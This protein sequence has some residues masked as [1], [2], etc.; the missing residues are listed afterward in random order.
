MDTIWT[1]VRVAVR[2]L[3]G[4]PLF[5]CTALIT[6][7]IG[8]GANSAIFTIVNGVLLR[9][10]PY[11][12]PGRLVM[13]SAV[14]RGETS[15]IFSGPVFFALQE[16]AHT[17]SAVAIT[18][19]STA[20]L[21]DDGAEP[22]R[23]SGMR[24][25]A[26]YFD[27]VGITPLR[28]RTFRVE[29]NEP[30]TTVVILS[31]SLWRERFNGDEGVIGRKVE[32]NGRQHEIIGIM[33]ATASVSPE[34]RYWMPLSYD[35]FL[36][37]P[38]NVLSLSYQLVARLAPGVTLE[39]ASA[40]VAAVVE[41]T[42]QANGMEHPQYSGAVLP[43]RDVYVGDA[44]T[45]LLVLL[46]AV[47]F[48]LL[49]VCANLANLLL[50]QAAARSTDFAVRRALGAS[51][52][53]LVRQLMT[54][55][56]VLG[57]LGGAAGLLI[58]AWGAEALLRIMPPDLPRMPGMTIDGRVL[59]F[60]MGV[61]LLAAVLFGLAPAAHAWRTAVAPELRAGG[62]GLAGRGSAT[63]RAGLV[64]AETALAFALVIGAGLLIRSFSELRHV[65]TGFDAESRLTYSVNLPVVRSGDDERVTLFWHQLLERTRALPGVIQ[66]GAV[67]HL[68][69]GGSGMT[70]TF[71]VEGMPPAT[72][73]EEPALEVRVATPGYFEAMGI[74]LRVGRLFDDSDRA[75]AMP[76]ALLSESAAAR[77]FPGENPIGRRIIMGWIRNDEEVEGT[78]IGVVGSVRHSELR[79][80]SEAEI[81]FPVA[82]VGR[83]AM[84]M[85]LHTQG[86]PLAVAQA[87]K[88]VVH[89]LDG[90]LAVGEL[91]P[92]SEVVAMSAA[93]D[94]FMAALLTAFSIMALLLAAVGIFGVISYGVVQRRREIGVRLAV[95]ASRGDVVR[96]IVAGAMRLAGAGLIIGMLAALALTRLIQSL[97]YGVAPTDPVT[98]T[99]AA[100]VLLVVA[101]LASMLP[102]LRASRT[103]PAMVLNSE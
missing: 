87:A 97:L 47:G 45:P 89:E 25:S 33:P 49:I 74:P 102:A 65:D 56:L 77:H 17:L 11:S 53:Q 91:R 42:K 63:T 73:G 68:P 88:A 12:D 37:D 9:P 14:M 62:R 80:V 41:R 66:A 54:E 23:V 83:N 20:T 27:V 6:L 30:G 61:S 43:L 34:W 79:S 93:T 40:D 32:M 86:D 96:L 1:G 36:R 71:D 98:F 69:L 76:V 70:I 31:E 57:V 103:P 8:I 50:A 72:P 100:L 13:P 15:P 94:R 84:V 4:D 26:N 2:R 29:E 101:L 95:G 78:V 58:G 67:Q 92:M 44:R 7:A 3:F 51:P 60:T 59:I 99:A 39:Q 64:L 28:G 38:G 5:L 81:Y 21:A 16:Q 18:T 82:Q 90:G 55:S 19:A 75:G 48:V 10:L 35:S 85:V 22:E 46:G 52:W 24:T